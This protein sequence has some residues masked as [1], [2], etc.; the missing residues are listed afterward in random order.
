ML[1][2][3]RGEDEEAKDD[4]QYGIKL[5]YLLPWL[6]AT[7]IGAYYINYHDKSPIVLLGDPGPASPYG[8]L[9]SKFI[10]DIKLYGFSFS[11]MLGEANLSGEFSY[12]QDV[13][14]QGADATGIPMVEEG[15]YW[16]AQTSAIY[17][18]SLRSLADSL[19]ITGEVACGKEVGFG[20]EN[21]FAWMYSVRAM[22]DWFE[23]FPKTKVGLIL[24]GS[25]VV[26]GSNLL[27]SEGYASASVGIDFLYNNVWK[28]TPNL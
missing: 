3:P 28:G 20:E 23:V 25:D 8:S 16:Q 27:G 12:R 7:E 4:G 17:M 14:F 1:A 9:Y 18:R 11:S 2:I 26:G 13:G 21:E 15:D 19:T 5:T 24:A 22:I 10:E 6:D